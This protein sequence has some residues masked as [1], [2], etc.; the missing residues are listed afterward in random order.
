MTIEDILQLIPDEKLP[1]LQQ[2]FRKDCPSTSHVYSLIGLC[3]EWRKS[4]PTE[5]NVIFYCPN[6]DFN[7]GTFVVIMEVIF[8]VKI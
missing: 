8:L 6:G 5:N 2:L 3:L 1:E 4:A 7:D